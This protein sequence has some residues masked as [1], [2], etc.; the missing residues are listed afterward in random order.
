MLTQSSFYP[1][2]HL[3]CPRLGFM[4]SLGTQSYWRVKPVN[5]YIRC[6]SGLAQGKY[7]HYCQSFS[8]GSLSLLP[9][10]G[11]SMGSRL[12]DFGSLHLPRSGSGS[13]PGFPGFSLKGDIQLSVK[14]ATFTSSFYSS[15]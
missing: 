1:L 7:Y 2:S 6:G 4:V 13:A 10:G 3:P 9:L 12:Q 11:T 5:R 8:G 14:E 15:L